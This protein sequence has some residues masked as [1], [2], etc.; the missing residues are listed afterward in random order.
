MGETIFRSILFENRPACSYTGK[1]FFL[2]IKTN[3]FFES[4]ILPL[5]YH[6]K[7]KFKVIYDQ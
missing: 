2:I 1:R 3:S 4:S 6:L 5:K 7:Q